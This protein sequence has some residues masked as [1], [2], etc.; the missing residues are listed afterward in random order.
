[1]QHKGKV[2]ELEEK[3]EKRDSKGAAGRRVD[4]KRR[5]GE[6]QRE[7][8]PTKEEES[9]GEKEERAAKLRPGREGEACGGEEGQ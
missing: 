3:K 8:C 6:G 2:K 1:M 7:C 9:P 4:S 5:K